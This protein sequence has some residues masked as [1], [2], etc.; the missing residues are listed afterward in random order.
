MVYLITLLS[1]LYSINV[2]GMI[3]DMEEQKS[4]EKNLS[5]GHFV[6]CTSHGPHCVDQLMGDGSIVCSERRWD[7]VM[8]V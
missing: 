1:T 4:L 2:N 7:F 6:S 3:T 8:Y 5:Q